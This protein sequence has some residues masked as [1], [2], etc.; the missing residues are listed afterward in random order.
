MKIK[1]LR[2]PKQSDGQEKST[3]PKTGAKIKIAVLVVLFL[4]PLAKGSI[5]FAHKVN[6]FAYVEGDTVYTESY[7]SDG[8]KVE[9]GLIEIYDSRE[10]K[11]LEGKTD[12]EG[13]FNFKPSRKDDLK[14]V[15]IATMGHKN[16]YTLSAEE[17]SETETGQKLRERKPEESEIK[18][19]TQIDLDQIEKIIEGCLDEK[20]R[21]VMRQLAR[22]QQKEVSFTEVVGG[23]GYIFGIMGLVLYFLS[24]KR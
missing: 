16:S 18:E 8:K 24:K 15:L 6:I 17:L 4:F 3:P 2:L 21:P 19:I 11:L 1:N 9:G 5:A 14:I 7:F 12:K 23:I 10:S 20:L 22:A 13:R